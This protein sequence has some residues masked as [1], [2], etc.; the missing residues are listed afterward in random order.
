LFAFVQSRTPADHLSRVIAGNNVINALF[1][2]L[3]AGLG[4][5][6]NALG[7]SVPQI[8]LAAALLGALVLGGIFLRV[9]AFVAAFVVWL[10]RR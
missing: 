8:L 1:I 7:A 10:R 6:L 9:P 5:A 4:L 3:A 2:C